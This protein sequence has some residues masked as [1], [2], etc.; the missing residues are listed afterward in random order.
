M[1]GG[2]A[3]VRVPEARALPIH[4]RR[5]WTIFR[6]PCGSGRRSRRPRSPS[7]KDA[8][9]R[10][11]GRPALGPVTMSSAAPRGCVARAASGGG[12]TGSALSPAWA[13]MVSSLPATLATPPP[14]SCGFHQCSCAWVCCLWGPHPEKG[15]P[16]HHSLLLTSPSGPRGGPFWDYI[17]VDT[18]YD[19]AHET[20]PPCTHPLHLLSQAQK[21]FWVEFSPT[22]QPLVGAERALNIFLL[23][24]P[25]LFIAAKTGGQGH[26]GGHNPVYR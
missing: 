26:Q 4:C 24:S 17:P 18:I 7:S 23:A 3:Q 20:H 25:H 16:G 6:A 21:R 11:P 2:W 15:P 5:Y 1:E 22:W 9:L 8:A 10:Q 19:Q 13:A 14:H 12:W